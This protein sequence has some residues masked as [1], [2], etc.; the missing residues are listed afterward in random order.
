[1]DIRT[2]SQYLNDSIIV[3]LLEELLDY[4]DDA[5][6]EFV[7]SEQTVAFS[8]DTVDS[9]RGKLIGIKGRNVE[10]IRT[11]CG[12]ICARYRFKFHLTVVG[13]QKRE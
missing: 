3:P 11:L 2:L 4:A 10:A 7:F 5:K 8:I 9:D 6:V 12:A 1:M 13:A